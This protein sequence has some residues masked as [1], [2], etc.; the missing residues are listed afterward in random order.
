M[1]AVNTGLQSSASER[2]TSATSFDM[3]LST[4]IRNSSKTSSGRPIQ[5]ARKT[6]RVDNQQVDVKGTEANRDSEMLETKAVEV[7]NFLR[8]RIVYRE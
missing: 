7:S 4:G 8:S 5:R 2:A 1:L 6:T 3:D